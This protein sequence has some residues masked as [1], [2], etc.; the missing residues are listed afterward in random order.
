M[1]KKRLS[2]ASILLTGVFL[3]PFNSS[4][5]LSS[6]LTPYE[7]GSAGSKFFDLQVEKYDLKSSEPHV[8]AQID[9]KIFVAARESSAVRVMAYSGS[10]LNLVQEIELPR[11]ADE[12][13]GVGK[14]ILD[15]ETRSDSDLFVSYLEWYD[16]VSKCDRVVVLQ[17]RLR[18][19][20]IDKSNPKKV[21]TSTPCWTMLRED[22]IRGGYTASGRLAVHG[23]RLFVEGGMVMIELGHNKY[24][25]PGIGGLSGKFKNDVLKTNLFGSV[26]E[27]DLKTLKWTKLSTGHRNPQ[28][29]LF[30]TQ[31]NLLWS[32]EHGP[33]GG[34]ELN[35]IR[36]GKNYGWPYVS[37]GRE[38]FDQ[39]ILPENNVFETR[40][41]THSGY[42]LPAFAWNPSIG[43]S[44]LVVVPPGHSFGPVWTSDLLLSSLR[45]QSIYRIVADKTG[46]VLQTERISIGYRIRDLTIGKTDVW[47]ST[48]D[49]RLLRLTRFVPSS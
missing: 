6:E 46:R 39:D 12:K 11:L 45:D 1:W 32:A 36:K 5:A 41:G 7:L 23:N 26:T 24:P 16:D 47:A 22:S 42:E 3:L 27:V 38:Y 31:R 13:S 28:G 14:Y 48:D 20:R 17:Y 15:L 35:I 19:D 4:N 18:S 10:A 37:L 44:Q 2:F 30:D 43:P 29:L 21:F 25:N 34:C 33:S 49:G 9:N 8:I 40:Y